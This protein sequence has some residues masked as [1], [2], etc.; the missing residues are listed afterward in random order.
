MAKTKVVGY[1]LDEKMLETLDI[2]IPPGVERGS[3]E[4]FKHILDL[5]LAARAMK[6]DAVVVIAQMRALHQ[7]RDDELVDVDGYAKKKL[8]NVLEQLYRESKKKPQREQ[9]TLIK[10][11]RDRYHHD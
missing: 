10:T 9:K 1:R 7:I 11:Y 8:S 4:T 2:F 5:A 3:T 6:S